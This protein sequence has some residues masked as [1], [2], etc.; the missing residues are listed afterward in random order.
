MCRGNGATYASQPPLLF[1]MTKDFY[2][3]TGDRD[4]LIKGYDALSLE[5][6]FWTEKR[7]SP[8]G[9][10]RYG[11]NFDY[12]AGDP[13][14]TEFSRRMKRDFNVLPKEE[15]IAI[16]LDRNA[17][18][19]SGHDYSPRFFGRAYETNPVDLNSYL[20]GFERIM[21]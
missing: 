9:L 8:S 18:G 7:S 16:A 6:S 13:D 1:L 3:H 15:K 12:S 20:Y 10:N 14:L 17:E 19:E 4:F 2:V 5:Y 21:A 11:S